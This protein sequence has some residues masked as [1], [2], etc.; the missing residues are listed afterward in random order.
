MTSFAYIISR[1]FRVFYCHYPE[2]KTRAVFTRWIIWLDLRT[3]ASTF[4]TPSS[5]DLDPQVIKMA[6]SQDN[7]VSTSTPS[8]EH[9]AQNGDSSVSASIG[10]TFTPTTTNAP[11]N[12]TSTTS[13]PSYIVP[14][15]GAPPTASLPDNTNNQAPATT[16]QN[17]TSSV[18]PPAPNGT[19]LP[20]PSP[21]APHLTPCPPGTT[22][23]LLEVG[24][25]EADLAFMV[26]GAN[27][28]RFSTQDHPFTNARRQMPMYCILISHP[29]EGLILWETGGGSHFPDLVGP[30]VADVFARVKWGPEHELR[31]AI[32]ATGHRIEDVKKVVLGHLHIDHAGGLE[33][34]VGRKDVEVWVHDKELRGAFWS[35]AT[36]ADEGVYMAHCLR[37]DMN[38]KTFDEEHFEFAQ[39]ITLHHLPGHTEGLCA[40]QINLQDSGAWLFTSDMYHVIENLRDDVP[41]G[42]LQRD[43][44]AWFRSHNRVKNLQRVAR[45]RVIPGHDEGTFMAMQKESPDNKWS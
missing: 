1:L 11:Q 8:T 31:A 35:V 3:L 13:A 14:E 42:W 17:G 32:A 33:E 22:M 7:V 30:A 29:H 2:S 27:T 38:W 9:V 43:H 20:S 5:L 25:L 37:L 24:W 21:L 23:H 28:S 4:R 15:N 19:S 45:C 6:T 44:V 34:F 10:D 40:M 16:H 36:G 18:P 41:Q 39:G 12:D 26:R